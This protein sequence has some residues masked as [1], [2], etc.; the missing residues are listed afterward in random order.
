TEER[1]FRIISRPAT[2]PLVIR[3]IAEHPSWSTRIT[4]RFAL[5]RNF[6]TPMKEV[7]RFI[8]EL[9]AMDLKTLYS[10]PKLPSATKPFIYRELQ[11]RDETT[12]LPKDVVYKLEG[13]EDR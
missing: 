8:R 11:R 9:T 10:D 7:E 2:K 3:A 13:D 6:Y 4:I 5:V 1:L 12:D